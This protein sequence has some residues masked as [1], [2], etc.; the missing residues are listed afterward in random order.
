MTHANKCENAV[1][2]MDF[3]RLMQRRG[4]V[5]PDKTAFGF[6]ND[7]SSEAVLTYGELDRS[8]KVIATALQQR[9]LSGE[10][11]VLLFLPGIDYVLG[12]LGCWYAGVTAVPVYAPRLNASYERVCVIVNDAQA[13]VMLS[14]A[15][16]LAALTGDEWQRLRHRG[17]QM[18]ATDDLPVS[19][20]ADWKMPAVNGDTLAVLQYT[21]GSTG[22][23]KG[24]RVL[25]RHLIANSRMISRAMDSNEESVGVVWLPPY[26][27]MG[28]VGGILQPF[29]AGFPV[30]LMA[31]ATFLQRPMRWLEAISNYRATISAAPNFAYD[32]CVRRAKPAHIEQLDL[33]SWRVA[34]NGAEPIRAETLTR[35]SETFSPAGFDRRA[36]FPS[37]G[38]AETTL[39]VTASRVFGGATTLLAKRN[40]LALGSLETEDEQGVRLVSSGY[41]DPETEIAIV[42]PDSGRRCHAGEIG[43]IWVRGP[44]VTDGYWAKADATTET[45]H[46]KLRDDDTPWLRTGDLGVLHDHELYVTGR[47]K[48]LIV[49]RGHNYYPH[50]I[51]AT[52]LAAHP[53]IRAQGAAAFAIETPEGEGLGL[54]VEMDRGWQPTD[55]DEATLAV[56]NAI[57]CE[58]QLQVNELVFVRANTI[59][60]T[61][62]GKVQRLLVRNRWLAGNLEICAKEA[63]A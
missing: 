18:L 53:E 22:T 28:L 10:R 15:S 51:E 30:H 61:S 58:H 48:D 41:V 25:Q 12:I 62:S 45:F 27:D 3:V 5:T 37:Y 1:H 21:S 7:H 44:A 56:R 39:M 54:V 60:K 57:S 59:P 43:E 52:A 24:V 13:A 35:F 8:A 32:L 6:I 4:A 47:I 11:A 42:A 38:M 50:D 55:L 36:F 63:I 16:V 17:L 2:E 31:P 9:G 19:I 40:A 49:I 23:P 34:V 46:A 20:G 33:S 29:Y 14:T 26:H